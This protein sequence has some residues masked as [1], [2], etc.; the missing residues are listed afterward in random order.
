MPVYTIKDEQTGRTLDVRGD[1]P[2]TQEEAAALFA[3]NP[4][5]EARRTWTD[6]AV[7]ALPMAG[8]MV[9]GVAGTV[10][11]G[12]LGAVGGATLGGGAGEAAK[13][14]VNRVRGA[15]APQTS[16]DAA[17]AIAGQGAVNGALEGVGQAAMPVL[18]KA[19]AAV[20]RGYLK[21][22]LSRVNLPKAAQIVK[23]AIEENLPVTAAGL[24][25]ARELIGELNGKVNA[26]LDNAAGKTISL[27]DIAND[28][29]AWAKRMYD[30]PGRDPRDYEAVLKVADRI[31]PV[32]VRAGDLS[33][34]LAT[35]N[36]VKKDLQAS[37][38]DKFG[39]PNTSAEVAGE[40]YAS[41]A[42][43][44]AI[45]AEAPAVGPL[46]MRESQLIDVARSLARATGRDAN[47][48]RLYGV[49]ALV[50]GMVGGG[51]YARTRDPYSSAAIGL[52]SSMALDPAVAT[53]AAILAVKLGQHV[54]GTA[55][56][57]VARAAVQA[58]L[59]MQQQ[60]QQGPQQ[61]TNQ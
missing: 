16:G 11:G 7:D 55:V 25:R 33:V 35:G 58:A 56:A 8:G 40:K 37:A 12:P 4:V 38:A 24:S 29:R 18:E 53:R 19:G 43:R 39:L 59:E 30:R 17:L 20:Y 15:Q 1:S 3:A 54:P 47:T 10:A 42:T 5:P 6:T 14:L 9:G 28:V 60:P 31:D 36:T 52:A 27:T 57:D 2:P 34:D 46:N 21:P 49:R 22:S 26:I 48:Q 41:A 23:T 50:G 32:P 61:A 45:E 44:K 13:Q 51:E